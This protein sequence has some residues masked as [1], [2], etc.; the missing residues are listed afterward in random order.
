MSF[1]RT[2]GNAV[3]AV[4]NTTADTVTSVVPEIGTTV[5]LATEAINLGLRTIITELTSEATASE[6][7]AEK[8]SEL[9][10]QVAICREYIAMGLE[11]MLDPTLDQALAIAKKQM[12]A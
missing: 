5:K 8:L 9:K 12:E 7:A 10:A 2:T 1:I 11:D 4:A 6:V 3:S